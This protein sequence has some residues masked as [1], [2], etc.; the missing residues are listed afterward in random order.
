MTAE[1]NPWHQTCLCFPFHF[2]IPFAWLPPIFNQIHQGTVCFQVEQEPKKIATDCPFWG[3]I[4]ISW[5]QPSTCW[6]FPVGWGYIWPISKSPKAFDL[7]GSRVEYR[8]PVPWNKIRCSEWHPSPIDSQIACSFPLRGLSGDM[9]YF[10]TWDAPVLFMELK[11]KRCFIYFI[12]FCFAFTFVWWK[13]R[14]C[15]ISLERKFLY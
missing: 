3:V 14:L 6:Q 1:P 10:S 12:L 2:F 13:S 15:P 11:V 5:P 8:S 9:L 4:P 7:Q